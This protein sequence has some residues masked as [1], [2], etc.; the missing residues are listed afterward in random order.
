MTHAS[1]PAYKVGDKVRIVD[2]LASCGDANCRY[3]IQAG[4]EATVTWADTTDTGLNI[5]SLTFT[6]PNGAIVLNPWFD[7]EL[8]AV[9]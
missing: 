4:R 7:D 5:Y 9:R 2:N 8:E 6:G 1:E 3:C